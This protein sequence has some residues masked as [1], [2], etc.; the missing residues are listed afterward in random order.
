[1]AGLGAFLYLAA[2]VILNITITEVL[3]I[4][5]IIINYHKLT[6]SSCTSGELWMSNRNRGS[7]T[8][9]ETAE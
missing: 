6:S 9:F 2:S 1:M 5:V 8:E 4:P 7:R 3:I